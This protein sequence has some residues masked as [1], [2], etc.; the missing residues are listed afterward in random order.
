MIGR[1]QKTDR[2]L[3]SG[4]AVSGWVVLALII[5]FAGISIALIALGSQAY[6][7]IEC[8]VQENTA[9]RTTSGY[10]LSR[11]RAFD[12]SQAARK[13]TVCFDGKETDVLTLSQEIE[14]ECY[15]ARL[16]CAGGMLREQFVPAQIP[17]ESA[18]DGEAVAPLLEMTVAVEGALITLTM[19][20][21]D[22]SSDVVY[23]ALRSTQEVAAR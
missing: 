4:N 23:A 16:F 20:A 18:E 8:R 10:V 14:G 1:K 21:E 13:D 11:V 3:Q 15:E 9:L 2:S 5:L 6:Q 17:L 22:G 12:A 19:T 7:A